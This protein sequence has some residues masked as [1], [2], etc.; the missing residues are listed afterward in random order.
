MIVLKIISVIVG[1]TFALFGYL[2][3]F[4]KK[5]SLI[6][7]SDEEFKAGRK[8]E[9]YAKR[10]GLIELTIGIAILIASVVLIIFG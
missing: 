5:Y 8:T 6:N 7:G 10:V 1:L 2:I 4:R 3:F 9:Q